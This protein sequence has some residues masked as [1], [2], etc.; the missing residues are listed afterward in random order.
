MHDALSS[1][2][3]H[4]ADMQLRENH[5]TKPPD[6]CP[7]GLKQLQQTTKLTSLSFSASS[8]SKFPRNVVLLRCG[9]PYLGLTMAGGEIAALG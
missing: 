8:A 9:L 7:S 2:D 1:L 4:A 6:R 3:S 5:T